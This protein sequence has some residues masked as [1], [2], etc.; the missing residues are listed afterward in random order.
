[1]EIFRSTQLGPLFD[2]KLVLDHPQNHVQK[3]TIS[4]WCILNKNGAPLIIIEK[5]ADEK[6]IL[7][8][9][10]DVHQTG[11]KQYILQTHPPLP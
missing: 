11:E 6:Y 9:N 2:K 10:L 7:L 5:W 3:R 8:N 4:K 1:M